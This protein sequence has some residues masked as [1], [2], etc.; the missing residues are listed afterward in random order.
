MRKDKQPILYVVF[1]A[2]GNAS[3]L[4]ESLGISKQAVARWKA[5]PFR[6]LK[7]IS[8]VTGISR[9]KLRPDLYD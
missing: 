1:R 7:T 3:R 8:D 2:Y 5:V 4:A 9:R 6:H